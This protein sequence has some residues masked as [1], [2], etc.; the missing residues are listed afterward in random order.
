MNEKKRFRSMLIW[1]VWIFGGLLTGCT[2]KSEEGAESQI[3]YEY[4]TLPETTVAKKADKEPDNG[5][6]N[7]EETTKVE[8]VTT[9]LPDETKAKYTFRRANAD[10]YREQEEQ[11]DVVYGSVDYSCILRLFNE[12][13]VV[14]PSEVDCA[15]TL[16]CIWALF[17]EPDDPAM[18]EDFYNYLI[19]AEDKDGNV[20]YLEIYQYSGMPSIGG[21]VGEE[22]YNYE[23]A[24][25]ELAM[26]ISKTQLIPLQ[27]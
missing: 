18:Y 23:E 5:K 16:G 22:F 24:A 13:Q 8:E 17:G 11:L 21:P 15:R 14:C 9:K 6:H 2:S 4:A 20:L 1:G 3:V 10:M 27:R 25:R 26:L 19:A 12:E 7:D